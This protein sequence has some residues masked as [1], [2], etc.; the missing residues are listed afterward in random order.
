MKTFLK[1]FIYLFCLNF[2][3]L[4]FS[5]PGSL[6]ILGGEYP[7]RSPFQEN[8][9]MLS[10]H[11]EENNTYEIT[12]F[13]ADNYGL[14][15]GTVSWFLHYLSVQK[16]KSNVKTLFDLMLKHEKAVTVMLQHIDLQSERFKQWMDL[17]ETHLDSEKIISLL[18]TVHP[19]A[20]TTTMQFH[21]LYK[22]ATLPVIQNLKVLEQYIASPDYSL[23]LEI[24]TSKPHSAEA[25]SLI[26]FIITDP[27]SLNLVPQKTITSR[28]PL[29][30]KIA[31]LE[32]YTGSKEAF[33]NMLHASLGVEDFGGILHIPYQ[34]LRFN[35]NQIEKMADK[36][37]HLEKESTMLQQFLTS[38]RKPAKALTALHLSRGLFN[39][40]LILEAD[41]HTLTQ[42]KEKY[43]TLNR[44]EKIKFFRTKILPSTKE[45]L[46]QIYSSKKAK[47]P[48]LK[49]PGHISQCVTAFTGPLPKVF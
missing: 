4:A 19:N 18:T 38:M 25:K 35:I 32:N 45:K 14:S 20:P 7:K 49:G 34:I 42:T 46:N 41:S 15:F 47:K 33:I 29:F 31:F 43:T 24:Q 21:A 22:K 5:G 2:C 11:V 39:P 1:F 8:E 13:L 17:L 6:P 12:K 16:D 27:R 3:L 10:I 36:I 26:A 23:S 9:V 48:Q 30:K 44:K 37:L 28:H 40:S